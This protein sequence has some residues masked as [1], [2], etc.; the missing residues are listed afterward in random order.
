MK[1]LA[2]G[3]LDGAGNAS[4]GLQVPNNASLVGLDLYLQALVDGC[5]SNR[6]HVRIDP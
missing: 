5:L 2:R 3:T 6:V 4:F 1:R